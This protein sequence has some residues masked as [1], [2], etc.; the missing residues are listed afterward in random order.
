MTRDF[1]TNANVF[2]LFDFFGGNGGRHFHPGVEH[3]HPGGKHFNPGG[4]SRF[5]IQTAVYY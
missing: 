2:I 3:L 5:E 4:K 1:S